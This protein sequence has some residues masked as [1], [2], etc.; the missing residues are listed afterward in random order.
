M[1]IDVGPRALIYG[2]L[3]VRLAPGIAPASIAAVAAERW[4]THSLPDLPGSTPFDFDNQ[5]VVCTVHGRLILSGSSVWARDCG[6]RGS[7]V[8]HPL[9]PDHP[10]ARGGLWNLRTRE[11]KPL[12]QEHR[13]SIS[14]IP[15]DN[16]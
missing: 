12:G 13:D 4:I 1:E 5:A 14:C 6:L 7:S 10:L 16:E 9:S 2:K 3:G 15:S 11:E 8:A